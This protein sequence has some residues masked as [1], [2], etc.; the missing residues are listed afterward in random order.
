MSLPETGRGRPSVALAAHAKINLGLGVLALRADGFHDLDTLFARL[1]LHDEV[2]LKTASSGVGGRC[3]T[4]ADEP[5]DT[6]GLAMDEDNLAYRA[7]RAYLDTAASWQETSSR[8]DAPGVD[9]TLVKRIPLAAGLGGGSSDA[10]AVLRGL[11]RLY[12]AGIEAGRLHALAADLGS[13]VAFF[14]S[15]L[16]AAR[17]RGR[18]EVLEAVT[19]PARWLVLANPGVAVSA[20]AAYARLQSFTPPLRLERIR[21]RLESGAEPGYLNALEAGVAS[22][23]PRVREVLGALR[24]AGLTGVLMSGS[25]PTCFGLAV[26]EAEAVRVASRLKEEH[27]GWWLKATRLA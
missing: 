10:A 27:P 21:R 5:V 24:E 22:A 19:V 3:L 8:E 11:A 23:E 18:G 26:G 4:D 17:G 7:A 13:D 14:L 15:G 20:G 12:P 1:A 16:A 9:I 25:G 2:I 6:A